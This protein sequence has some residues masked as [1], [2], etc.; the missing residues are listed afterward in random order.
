MQFKS[1]AFCRVLVGPDWCKAVCLDMSNN[2]RI[3]SAAGC[4]PVQACSKA[5]VRAKR[6]LTPKQRWGE[7]CRANQ[8]LRLQ[9]LTCSGTRVGMRVVICMNDG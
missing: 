1:C 6:L 4:A 2:D 3:L 8:N 7:V 5:L 9:V